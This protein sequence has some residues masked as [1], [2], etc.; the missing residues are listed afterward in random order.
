MRF[1]FGGLLG[2]LKSCFITRSPEVV[3]IQQLP[4][5][6]LAVLHGVQLAITKHRLNMTSQR[7]QQQHLVRHNSVPPLSPGSCQQMLWHKAV[8]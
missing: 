3:R 1:F 4:Q 2:A 6:A 5:F 8:A 7:Q